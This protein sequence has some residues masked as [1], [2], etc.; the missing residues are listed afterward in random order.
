MA[1]FIIITGDK[2]MFIPAFGQAVVV[3]QPGTMAGSGKS[4]AAGKPVGVAGDEGKVL[5]PGCTY[6]TP[7][8]SIPGVGI[9]SIDSLGGDQT[10]QHTKS[11]GKP[12]LL[13]GSTF[14]AKFK[15]AT[16]AQQ[17]A[18]PSPIPDATTE[19]KGTG[20]FITT[21]LTVKGT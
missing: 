4:N 21:N 11:G 3:V 8:Y 18:S 10:A 1:D 19:Y 9:L 15:V 7:Q 16:P 17:P 2:A 14:N 12:V 5:V 6:M 13:K 20:M